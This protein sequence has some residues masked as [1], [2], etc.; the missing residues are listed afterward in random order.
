MG[1]EYIYHNLIWKNIHSNINTN[2]IYP[3][4]KKGDQFKSGFYDV[5]RSTAF[6]A[7]YSV[8]NTDTKFYL[9]IKDHGDYFQFSSNWVA[10]KMKGTFLLT[11][12][13]EIFNQNKC[14][15]EYINWR[16]N[17]FESMLILKEKV[18][19][20]VITV[21]EEFKIELSFNVDLAN[22]QNTF[23][24][25]QLLDN[26]FII[27]LAQESANEV[28]KIGLGYLNVDDKTCIRILKTILEE[29]PFA[30]FVIGL[31]YF[32]LGKSELSNQYI[33]NALNNISEHIELSDELI[34]IVTET[35]A[36]NELNLG[37]ADDRT[38]RAFFGVLDINQSPTALIKLSYLILSK[39]IRH[40]KDFALENVTIA[41]DFCSKDDDDFSKAAGF[42]IICSILLWN[43][44][45]TEAEKYH[46]HFLIE[47]NDFLNFYTEHVEAYVILA[48][49]KN[50]INFIANLFLDFPHL[51][52]KFS[53]LSDAWSFKNNES[54]NSDWSNSNLYLYRK[55]VAAEKQYCDL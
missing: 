2:R 40:L 23:E 52:D 28:F 46:H 17:L 43:D 34:G 7:D 49:A 22:L 24:P 38:I 18:R 33:V 6:L 19:D 8:K 30:G 44:K 16:G 42:Y 13:E 35:I 31:A 53:G 36:T 47:N 55:I 32:N 48:L 39:N 3:K 54:L 26:R 5:V 21:D 20:F 51:R 9:S 1:K 25:L 29:M 50:N 15:N 45:F 4:F 14:K 41:I 10:T 11:V 37:I 27:Q 12:H